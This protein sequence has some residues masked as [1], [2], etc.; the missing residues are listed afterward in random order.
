MLFK[1]QLAPVLGG[2][3]FTIYKFRTMVV[4]A[5]CKKGATPQTQRA[6]RPGVQNQARSANHSHRTRFFAKPASMNCHS[7]LTSSAAT[8]RWLD[9][10]P[11]RWKSNRCATWASPPCSTSRRALRCIW[12]IKGRVQRQLRRM[13]PHG[14]SLHS[15]PFTLAGR[16]ETHPDDGSGGPASAGKIVRM[17]DGN[18]RKEVG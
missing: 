5:E 12:Q 17:Q 8:C 6:G 2:K 10:G 18:L 14:P 9:P 7:F 11:C 3:P 1:Q 16:S 13:D 4:D 15:G